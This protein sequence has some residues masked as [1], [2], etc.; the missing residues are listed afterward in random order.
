MGGELGNQGGKQMWKGKQACGM[1]KKEKEG[2]DWPAYRIQAY[3]P[4][5]KAFHIF[6]I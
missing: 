6:T 4:K 5:H 3:N 1:E 2:I